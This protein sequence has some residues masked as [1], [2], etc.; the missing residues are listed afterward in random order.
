[1]YSKMNGYPSSTFRSSG[2]RLWG[3]SHSLPSGMDS[4][5]SY[6]S[7]TRM[8]DMP[9][10]STF[11]NAPP[12]HT[13]SSSTSSLSGMNFGTGSSN[14][15][16]TNLIVNYIPQDMAEG[17]LYSMFSAM[18][19][20]ET[21]RIMRDVKTGYSFGFGFVNF[22]NEEAA[23]RAIRCLNGYTVRGKRLKVSFARPQSDALKETNLYITNLPRTITEDQLDIIF[24]KYGLIVQ[25]NIL[26]DKLTGHP[27]G[28][29]FVRYNKREEAQEAISALNNVIPQ[30]GTQPLNV[31]VAEDHGRAKAALFVPSYNSI[32][33][34]NRGRVRVRNNPY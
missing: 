25:K 12:Q 8:Y 28:V 11:G 23:Q 14:Y 3:M 13:S 7:R 22:L 33:H 17:E 24:G 9:M 16:G 18:G 26:R 21:C 15:S 10:S 6:S 30:G 27:R 34:N 32:V 29:A 31:R 2:G 1:M 19:A 20:I 4:D 5:F